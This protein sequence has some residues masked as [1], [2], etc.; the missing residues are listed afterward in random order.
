MGKGAGPAPAPSV[1]AAQPP[2]QPPPAAAPPR[3]EPPPGKQPEAAPAA[4][5]PK[6]KNPCPACGVEIPPD[7]SF[8]GKCGYKLGDPLPSKAS[9]AAAAQPAPAPAPAPA[10]KP[11]AA[12]RPEVAVRGKIVMIQPSGAE[13]TSIPL[14]GEGT[15]IGRSAGDA[16]KDD[17]FLSPKHARFTIEGGTLTVEDIGSLNGIFVRLAPETLYD[18]QSGDLIRIGQEVMRFE[19]YDVPEKKDTAVYGSPRK[20]TWGRIALLLGRD[21]L[22][23]AFAL[24]GKETLIGRERGNVIF[25]DDGYVSGLHLKITRNGDTYTV[26]DLK[27]SNGSYLR[28]RDKREVKGGDYLLIGQYLYRVDF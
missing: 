24:N 23:N 28:I 22:G 6:E 5:P 9:P 4:A 1:P 8:C 13:G 27:S 2:A 25:P 12:A 14:T 16:F 11:A 17:Y 21:K 26:T 18:I 15:E 19:V 3:E 7:F 20:E 10:A